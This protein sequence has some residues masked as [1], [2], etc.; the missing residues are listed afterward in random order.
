MIEIYAP[1]GNVI[2]RSRN[3][4]GVLDHARRSWVAE[5]VAEPLPRGKGLLRVTFGDGGTCVTEFASFAVLC[6]WLRARRSWAGCR[7]IAH[8][9]PF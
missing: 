3:L 2:H 5:A 7:R 6:T 9:E 1:D 8:A 4:R